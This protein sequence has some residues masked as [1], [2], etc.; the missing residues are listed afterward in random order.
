MIL[1]I[2]T[3]GTIVHIIMTLGIMDGLGVGVIPTIPGT[4]VI[5]GGHIT[6]A[7]GAGMEE[8]GMVDIGDIHL[9]AIEIIEVDMLLQL[10]LLA[11]VD[12]QALTMLADVH[13]TDLLPMAQQAMVAEAEIS[14][15]EQ[16]A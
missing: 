6:T 3:P 13:T 1:G 15:A 14:T 7:V 12:G 8:A 16:V 9:C 5:T 10:I 11:E 2:T 4:Q